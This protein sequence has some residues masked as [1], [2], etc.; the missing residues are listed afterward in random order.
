MVTDWLRSSK[1]R[2]AGRLLAVGHG[3]LDVGKAKNHF[4][5]TAPPHAAEVGVFSFPACLGA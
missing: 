5:R 3:S 1:G 4:I 2:G